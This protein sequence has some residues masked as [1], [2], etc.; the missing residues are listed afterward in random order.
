MDYTFSNC[1]CFPPTSVALI[2]PIRR[3]DAVLETF[4][5]LWISDLILFN[6]SSLYVFLHECTII[7]W[8]QPGFHPRKIIRIEKYLLG[9]KALSRYFNNSV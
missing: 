5:I 9:D 4:N 3:K 6:L 7:E 8:S 2:L 1:E